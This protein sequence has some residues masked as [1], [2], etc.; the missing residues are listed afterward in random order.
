M[1][2]HFKR[3]QSIMK[4]WLLNIGAVLVA[5]TL[6]T[7]C[8]TDPNDMDQRDDDNAPLEEDQNDDR[9]NDDLQDDQD[10]DDQR[11]NEDR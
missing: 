1:K 4:K 7:A 9:P 2:T 5:L 11:N 3:R 10:M 6:V 8:N